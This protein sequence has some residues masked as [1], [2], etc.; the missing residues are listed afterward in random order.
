M[1]EPNV[2]QLNFEPGLSDLPPPSIFASERLSLTFDQSPALRSTSN[3][4][5][6]EAEVVS[7]LCTNMV[8]PFTP[9]PKT[10]SGHLRGSATYL[11]FSFGE[12]VNH[13]PQFFFRKAVV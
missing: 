7:S 10:G 4:F 3:T 11:P 12:L 1:F 13:S 2:V 8:V 6:G 5:A 9:G